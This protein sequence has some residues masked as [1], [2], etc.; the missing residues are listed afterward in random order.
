[1]DELDLAIQQYNAAALLGKQL[2]LALSAHGLHFSE[3]LLM[4]Y[5]QQTPDG[6]LSRIALAD[7]IGLT[8]SGVTRMLQPMEKIGW[9]DRGS[10]PR[11]ARQNLVVLSAAGGQRYQDALT[12]V[13]QTVQSVFQWFTDDDKQ[14]LAALL[15]KWKW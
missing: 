10:N 14:A 9:V 4:H 7:K 8:A 15:Q 5:L 2:D 13:K 1:M 3:F 12:T 11:D 6:T